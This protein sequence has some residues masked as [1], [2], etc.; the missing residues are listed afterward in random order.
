MLVDASNERSSL[1]DSSPKN[2]ITAN[3]SSAKPFDELWKVMHLSI[4]TMIVNLGGTVPGF[5]VASYIGR[6]FSVLDLDGFSLASMTSNLCTLSLLNGLYSASDTL[7]P[8]AYGLGN[9]KEVGYIAVR[10]MIGSLLVLIPTMIFLNVSMG[11]VLMAAG[12]DDATSVLAWRWYQ[13]YSICLPFHALYGFIW[14]FLSAQ[15][16][17]YPL[18][19]C[20]L[21]SIGL[22]L[23]MVL[24]SATT[25]RGT[26]YAMVF[27]E[28]F[29][30]C[31]L[32]LFLW[33]R[34]PHDPET[35]PG[36]SWKQSLQWKPFVTFMVRVMDSLAIVALTAWY[37][38]LEQVECWQVRSG[39]IGKA[40]AYS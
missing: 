34:Q 35:W 5:L 30:A 6:R 33:I 12:Q 37:R 14:K 38:R 40:S 27:F 9:K 39:S 3:D 16:T 36:L 15:D 29:Q 23:P 13:I 26:A 24:Y 21:V 28:V 31:S 7:S 11:Y 1:L 10:G 22:V 4:P 2:G 8:Q 20:V 32:L 19:L 18:V 25:F 17:M